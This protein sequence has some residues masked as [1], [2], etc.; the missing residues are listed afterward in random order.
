VT[1]YYY[2]SEQPYTAYDPVIQ[3]AYPSLR[4]TLP[5]SLFDPVV[6]SELYNRYHEEYQV[7]DELTQ[8]FDGIMI[9]EHHT[10]PFCMQAS[11]T[12]TGAILAKITKRVQI[13]MLGAPLP[14]V[15]NPLRLAEELAMIDCISRGRLI[16]GFV[17]GGGVETLA[18]NVNPAYNRERFEEAHDLL[19]AAWTRPGPFRWEGKHFEYRVVNPWVLPLQKPHPQ[20]MVPG[21]ASPE[22]VVWAAKHRY[23]Y[24]VLGSSL[25]QTEELVDLYRDTATEAG[26]VMGPEHIGYLIRVFVADTESKAQ[27]LGHN[28]FW[29]N[30]ALGKQPREWMAPPGYAT[31]DVAGI[32][33]L[34]AVSKPFDNQAYQEA[35]ANYQV[36]VGTPDQVLEKLRYVRD[37]LAVGHMCMWAQDGYIGHDDTVRCIELLGNEVLP[38]LRAD[39]TDAN[40]A[41]LGQAAGVSG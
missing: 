8:G 5:N 29:Q 37:R 22:T 6:A 19:I 3:D 41:A 7:V 26:Y 1:K 27:E 9:N 36:V 4:L 12:I 30:G 34:R 39:Q 16:S 35:Q 15:E 23:P 28:F 33:K 25:E 2:F 32:R 20:I 11:I 13:L 31:V 18:N 24:V 14:I 17:R 10:A 38:A 21:T 40:V